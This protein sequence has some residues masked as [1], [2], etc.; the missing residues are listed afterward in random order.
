M[1]P[2]DY[3]PLDAAR[4]PKWS[5]WGSKLGWSGFAKSSWEWLDALQQE[6]TNKGRPLTDILDIGGWEYEITMDPEMNDEAYP[7]ACGYQVYLGPERPLG[8]ATIKKM[9][10]GRRPLSSSGSER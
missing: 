6:A 1:Q 8:F 7:D 5:V 2:A 4:R 9:A 3:R 10:Q